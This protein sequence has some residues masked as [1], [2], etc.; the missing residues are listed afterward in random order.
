MAEKIGWDEIFNFSGK[1]PLKDVVTAIDMIT[2]SLQKMADASKASV[3]GLETDLGGLKAEASDL[4]KV[5]KELKIIQ[6][7]SAT[8]LEKMGTK[9]LDLTGKLVITKD[10]IDK[11]KK[12]IKDLDDQ[13]KSL[14]ETKEKTKKII[15][16]ETGSI[17]DLKTRLDAAKEAYKGMGDAT[18]KAVKQD[19]VNKINELKAAY[20]DQ[21]A[22]LGETKK[23]ADFLAGSYNELNAR[24]IAGKKELKAMEG[25]LEGNSLKFK[26]LKAE[27]KDNSDKLKAFDAG[28][29]DNTRTVGA[30]KEEIEKLLPGI[31]KLAPELV[32][33]GEGAAALGKKFLAFFASPIG[34]LIVGLVGSFALLKK[35]YDT[36][37]ESTVDGADRQSIAMA[38][39][40]AITDVL[41]T[42]F[43]ALGETIFDALGVGD[44]KGG[45][46]TGLISSIAQV[47]PAMLS[48]LGLGIELDAQ[49]ERNI[50]T[51]KLR[52]EI[53][54]EE[55]I[56]A[57]ELAELEL[58]KNKE[59]FAS[60]DKL[61]LSAEERYQALIRSGEISQKQSDLEVA[62]IDKQIAAI[63]LS[64]K[65]Q[66]D[67]TVKSILADENRLRK[68]GYETLEQLSE[69]ETKRTNA[70][71]KAFDNARNRQR[72]EVRL[73]EEQVSLLTKAQKALFDA[74]EANGIA[75]LNF[76]V[77][78][79]KRIVNNQEFTLDEQLQ[80]QTEYELALI[81]LNQ[82]SV[83]K[84]IADERAAALERVVIPSE[85]AKEI[86]DRTKNDL[87]ERARLLLAARNHEV[88]I[89]KTYIATTKA[90][91]RE[92]HEAE[93]KIEEQSGDDIAKI[94]DNNF[95]YYIQLRQ[96]FMQ[97]D[98]QA[99]IVELNRALKN[100][101]INLLQYNQQL[102]AIQKN[103]ASENLRI[104][105]EELTNELTALKEYLEKKETLTV[106]E[107]AILAKVNA[108]LNKTITDQ[109]Q[110]G[111][112]NYKKGL[113]VKAE[114]IRNFYREL[115]AATK[116]I[117]DNLFQAQIQQQNDRINS[118][119]EAQKR[120]LELIGEAN[121]NDEES[122]KI[123]AAR[124]LKIEQEYQAKIAIE[125]KKAK[126]LQRRQAIF[127]KILGIT[128]VAINTA[129]AISQAYA[130]FPYFIASGIAIALGAT[131]ALQAA[132][133]ASQPIPSYSVGTKSAKGGL[134]RVNEEGRE[135][136]VSP[137]G[138]ARMID[139][140]RAVLTYLE[141][142]SKV[143]TAQ[144]T[145]R[146]TFDSSRDA[147]MKGS[148]SISGILIDR[149]GANI[150]ST[151]NRGFE[152]L[153]DTIIN[154][155]EFHLNITEKG[156]D[157]MVRKGENWTKF[158]QANYP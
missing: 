147:Y 148:K 38:R 102:R 137:K 56:L 61:R 67:E 89:D 152:S 33:A 14:N 114:A 27:V 110:V 71:S 25:G 109:D 17:N 100:K 52:N 138:E 45:F 59:L 72:E 13:I 46:F 58:E 86:F 139:S 131:G 95:K 70:Q 104:Q 23:A 125:Q 157:Y 149:E 151:L 128:E 15:E 144:E 122:K 120:E 10:A 154:K 50:E 20:K 130:E 92:G 60:R 113:E 77:N 40:S 115:V 158:V 62:S 111:F 21:M 112:D 12:S 18:D 6:D 124:K 141:A 123:L 145:A 30:Y 1:T 93:K 132:V 43:K 36:Y 96:R 117:G 121:Q 64:K 29:G 28:I 105:G 135:L 26:A 119:E 156:I 47:N 153:Q 22:V 129:R 63:K 44:E 81:D 68:I 98:S 24:V 91:I 90:I 2:A 136:I 54:K 88:D 133:I 69:L 134:S 34:L 11:N 51:A 101:E 57:V 19:Q 127:D 106:Q 103:Q 53:R 75:Y 82:R 39:I 83:D 146:M 126:D 97:E 49:A 66:S 32:E 8:T 99:E 35:A 143:F 80:A 150:N 94:I 140:D 7:G 84:R 79:Q 87:D 108:E 74:N 5:V 118:L 4:I 9:S 155:K 55:I 31:K 142:G 42:K 3:G 65:I 41:K 78:N 48:L 85:V 16:N 107:A 76:V 73:V 116:Q 37:A